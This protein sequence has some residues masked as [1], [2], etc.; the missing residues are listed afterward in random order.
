MM[1]KPKPQNISLLIHA[2]ILIE[3][4]VPVKSDLPIAPLITDV[5]LID[6]LLERMI[7]YGAKHTAKM[8]TDKGL[9]H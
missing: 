7:R 3:Q 9:P 6:S 1:V 4:K 8:A 2:I 5:V